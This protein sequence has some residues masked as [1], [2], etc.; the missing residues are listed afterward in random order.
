MKIL[1]IGDSWSAGVWGTIDEQYKP[2]DA[3]YLT[4]LRNYAHVDNYWNFSNKQS[5]INFEKHYNHD[6]VLFFVTDPL[7]DLAA[8]MQAYN[9]MIGDIKTANDLKL[10]HQI[11]LSS[12][13]NYFQGIDNVFFIGGCQTLKNYQHGNVLID[14]VSHLITNGTY[15]HPAIYDSG[16]SGCMD[17]ENLD[18]DLIDLVYENRK[19]QDTMSSKKFSKWF[20]PE[21]YH[22]NSYS[23]EILGNE[24]AKKLELKGEI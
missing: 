16:W 13:I 21:G 3:G 24:I 6:V 22:P 10:A 20:G 17:L 7:R 15:T 23:H 9:F 18:R 4:T 14:S 12:T 19:Q 5:I 8:S 2:V 1:S 11:L